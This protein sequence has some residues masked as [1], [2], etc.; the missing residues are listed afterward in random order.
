MLGLKIPKLKSM[1]IKKLNTYLKPKKVYIPLICSDSNN[2]DLHIKVGD[3]VYKGQI[4]GYITEKYEMPIFSSVSGTILDFIEVTYKNGKKIKSIVVENDFKESLKER[5]EL[6]TKIDKISKNEFIQI[7]E[8]CGIIA[9]S[10]AGLPTY[11]KYKTNNKIK[12]LIINAVECEPYITADYTLIMEK[13]E[14][15]LETIDY[16]L[17]INDI[18]EAIIAIKDSNVEL[19]KRINKY[20]GTYLR[21][22]IYEVLNTYPIGWE[23]LLI[24]EIKKVNYDKLPSEKGIIVNNVSTIY[25]INQAIKYNKPIIERIV[26]FTGEGIKNPQNVLVK[27]GT[28]VKDVVK[29]IGGTYKN[30]ITIANGPMMG[31]LVDDDL[32]V[33]SDLNCVLILKDVKEFDMKECIRCG[34]CSHVCPAKLCPVLIKDNIDNNENLKKLKAEL[35][36]ECGLCTYICPSKIDVREYVKK[37]KQKIKGGE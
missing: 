19:I 31:I 20:I 14:D 37:A 35:C 23:R 33:T 10:G 30:T 36:C 7:I 9:M 5:Y 27:I 16:I 6:R 34:K 13:C 11:M 26:T 25:A 3:Y 21:I 15:I 1:S 4:L 18:D 8:K 2:I 28:K 24:K 12:T 17:D 22:R 32:V 29:E